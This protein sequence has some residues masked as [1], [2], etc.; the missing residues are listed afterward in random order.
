MDYT[1]SS[2]GYPTF[3][4]RDHSV[5]WSPDSASVIVA[6]RMAGERPNA[7]LIVPIAG[8]EP[9]V[10]LSSTP[11]EGGF[12]FPSIAPTGK[13][14]AY[15]FCREQV[16]DL[17]D[18]ALDA[19]LT[20]R[21]AP[22]RLTTRREGP[23]YGLSWT[24]DGESLVYGWWSGTLNLWRV[25]TA[26]PDPKRVELGNGGFRP[27]VSR[28]GNR[29]AYARLGVDSDIWKFEAGAGPTPIASSSLLDLDAMLS[30]DGSRLAFASDRTG[31]TRAIWVANADGSRAVRLTH[32]TRRFNGTPRWSSDGGWLAYDGRGENGRFGIYVIDSAGGSPRELTDDGAIPSWSRDGRWIYFG[33][34][35]SGITQIWR[36]PAVGGDAEQV[37]DNGGEAAWESWDGTMVYYN[38]QGGLYSR[39]VGGGPEQEVLSPALGVNRNFYPARDG[40]YYAIRP[41]AGRPNACE[42]RFLRFATGTSE[43]LYRFESLGLSQ[44]LSVS[45]DGNT[46]IFSGIS[47]SKNIDLML[48]QNFR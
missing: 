21:G 38:R 36:V 9:R 8:G 39:P 29:L 17:Y 13:S 41:D 32:E 16:C 27:A 14:L 34:G 22:R 30:P 23:I 7:V 15:A 2:L 31:D 20:A 25:S 10:M 44:G 37:T 40:I 43:T 5:S 4:M 18:I 24:A 6:A 48:V 47:P 33:S 28:L 26:R 11:A 45:P 19:Q 35:R 1:P 12:R 42:I 46:I 3:S